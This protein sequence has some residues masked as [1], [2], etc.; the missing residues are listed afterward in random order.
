MADRAAVL[1]DIHGNLPALEAVLAEV[2]AEGIDL[3][4][5]GGDS[6]LFGAHPAECVDHLRS[7]GDRL[8]A[9]RGN[10]DRYLIDPPAAPEDELDVVGWTR[11]A[12]GAE[13]T[14]WLGS[15]P[16]AAKVGHALVVHAGPHGDED[17]IGPDT[18][19]SELAELVSGVEQP[20]MLCGHIHVQYRRRF[21]QLELVN[22]GSVGLPFDGDPRSA[23]AV[24]EDGQVS[25][26]RTAYDVDS[27]IGELGRIGHPTA[28][29]ISDRLR[30]SAH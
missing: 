1:Y 22:P 20:L 14:H 18:P 13:R 21:E 19:D 4:V 23:W 12:L 11:A 26:R 24:L 2:R 8:V 25:F 27:V 3:L 16:P 7:F 30:R 15:L 28:D 10:C 9:V 6:A 29:M 17:L 5:C